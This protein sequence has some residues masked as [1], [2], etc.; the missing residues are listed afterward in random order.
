[1]IPITVTLKKEFL[2]GRMLTA[3]SDLYVLTSNK[4]TVFELNEEVPIRLLV[5]FTD[6][7][8]FLFEDNRFKNFGKT[9]SKYFCT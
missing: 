9:T 4:W 7:F 1:M 2:E 6:L 8:S 3:S 5:Q